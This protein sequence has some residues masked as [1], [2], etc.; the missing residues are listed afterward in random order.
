[1]LV[2]LASILGYWLSG[3]ALSPVSRITNSA[4]RIGVQN[5][6]E[7]LELPRAQ[8]ELRQLTETLNAMLGR[9]ESSVKRI[10]QFTAD[11]SHDLRTPIA[12]IR[13]NAELALR[14]PRTD[15]EYRET[16]SRILFTSVETTELIEKL[17]TLARADA[18]V[19]GL[20][21]APTDLTNHLRKVA[22]EAGVLA[23]GKN[24]RFVEELSTDQA[25][26]MADATAVE[27]M[28]IALLDNA[29]KYTPDG[30][31]VWLRS[32]LEN[33]CVVVEVQDTGIGIAEKD[34]PNIFE[35]FYRAEQSR[36][37]TIGGAGLG[38][39]IAKW[40]AETHQGSISVMSRVGEGSQFRV[41]LPLANE[42]PR[43]SVSNR[44]IP[45]FTASA[46]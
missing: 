28:M 11:A 14:R 31:C 40:V 1:M 36:T 12:L 33:E 35:R 8:D 15:A 22:E 43:A 30:G 3:K 42:L 44:E 18:G 6:S 16:L 10:T 27:R 20:H 34:L 24:I 39:S 9:I 21:F 45:H 38:L 4:A 37:R 5:L 26:V 46:D 2:V 32:Y 17:L 19:A 13:T 29:V 7:R 41:R 23:S 25:P